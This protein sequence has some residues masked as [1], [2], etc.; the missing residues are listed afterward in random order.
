MTSKKQNRQSREQGFTLIEIMMVVAIV[1]ILAAI[2]LPAY[3][4]YIARGKIKTAQADLTAL[5][6]NFENRYQRM[7]SYPTADYASATALK[8]AFPGWTPASKATDFSF[9]T[10]DTEAATYSVVATGLAGGVSGCVI[11]LKHDGSKT[12]ASCPVANSSSW[13]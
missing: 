3:N 8:T 4:N 9:A 5:S 13:L 6:L 1:A 7:L 12:I 11:T 2:A 10:A